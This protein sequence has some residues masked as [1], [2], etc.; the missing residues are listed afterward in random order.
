MNCFVVSLRPA[1]RIEARSPLPLRQQP[2][3]LVAPNRFGADA[4]VGG[5]S[6]GMP[7]RRVHVDPAGTIQELECTSGARAVRRRMLLAG[8]RLKWR[9]ELP[10]IL[11]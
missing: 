6:H 4:T 1:S 2:G 5:P 9:L 10:R 3:A 7:K 11:V 8:G